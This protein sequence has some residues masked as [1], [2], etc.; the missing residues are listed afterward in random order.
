MGLGDW[1]CLFDEELKS[2]FQ[3]LAM[4]GLRPGWAHS[5]V[6]PDRDYSESTKSFL[7]E[8]ILRVLDAVA[9]N[10]PAI[11]ASSRSTSSLTTT[12]MFRMRIPIQSSL[13]RIGSEV[14]PSVIA[15]RFRINSWDQLIHRRL[16]FQMRNRPTR[17]GA[18]LTATGNP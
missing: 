18:G 16:Q 13:H 11:A 9:D 12:S 15:G 17:V 10:W 6:R 1:P 3:C 2:V 5:T 7:L 14:F 8:L 4:S